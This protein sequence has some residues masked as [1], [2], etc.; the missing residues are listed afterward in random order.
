[1]TLELSIYQVDAFADAV[2]GGN[3]AA[4]VPLREWLP[5]PLL[6]AIAAENNLAETAFLVADGDGYALRWFTPTVEV[7]LC[8]HATLASAAIIFEFLKPASRQVTFTTRRAGQLRVAQK[9]DGLLE[10]DFPARPS[11]PV[12]APP[13]LAEALGAEPR[14][15]LAHK[16]LLAVFEH[17]DE[18]RRLTPDFRKLAA[19][20]FDGVIATAPGTDGFDFV[21]RYFAPHVGI[22]EDPVTGSAHCVLAPFWAGRLGRPTLTGRQISRR[23]GT[24]HV[25]DRGA[26]VLLSGRTQLYMEGR[27]YLPN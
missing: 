9:A 24:V 10:M 11:E 6:Q 4:V 15:V 27:L 5:D 14:E 26:R 19:L 3:P 25:E 18:V 2:F 7:E 21:S 13:G 16:A 22:D 23:S 1:M 12:T 17:A 20:P 8:G